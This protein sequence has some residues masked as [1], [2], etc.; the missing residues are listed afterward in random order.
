MLDSSGV[1]LGQQ[2]KAGVQFAVERLELHNIRWRDFGAQRL[3]CWTSRR[4][5]AV[6]A[7][8]LGVDTEWCLDKSAGSLSYP[9]ICLCDISSK[10]DK[11]QVF[12]GLFWYAF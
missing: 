5:L 7:S 8:S 6:G 11:S 12:T 4:R 2:V 3:Y 1:P 9:P 10:L